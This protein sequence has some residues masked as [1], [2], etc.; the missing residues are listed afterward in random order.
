[1][2]AECKNLSSSLNS[3][4]LRK[5]D[6]NHDEV[7]LQCLRELNCSQ[8]VR[9]FGD[10]LEFRNISE[11]T[12]HDTTDG[13]EVIYHQNLQSRFFQGTVFSFKKLCYE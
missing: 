13:E 8:P 1:M 6:V 10:D 2:R 9:R 7:W 4:Q 12:T 11:L 3:I 5:I